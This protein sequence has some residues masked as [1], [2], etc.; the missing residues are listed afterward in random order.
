MSPLPFTTSDTNSKKKIISQSYFHN[1][2]NINASLPNPYRMIVNAYAPDGN[3]DVWIAIMTA[4]LLHIIL[5]YFLY[6]IPQLRGIWY[7]RIRR[8]CVQLLYNICSQIK[9]AFWCCDF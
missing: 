7:N 5:D 6:D 4:T 9:I 2:A 8:W 3:G 1:I